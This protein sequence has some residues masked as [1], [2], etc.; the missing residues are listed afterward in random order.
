MAGIELTIAS[1]EVILS[2]SYGEVYNEELFNAKDN[3]PMING[4]FCPRIFGPIDSYE[5]LCET[6]I[7]NKASYCKICGVD[8]SIDKHNAR[9]R[10]GHIQLS[11][12]IVH[13]WLYKSNPNVLSILLNKPVKYIQ[14][15]V[16][17]ELHIIT[18]TLTNKFRIGQA[19]DTNAYNKI[20]NKGHMYKALSGGTAI[21]KLLSEVQPKQIR[22]LILAKYK[23]L[24]SEK[25]LNE[26]ND[27]LNIINNFAND[28]NNNII[29]SKII[30]NFLPVLP[31]ILRPVMI[32]PDSTHT[33]SELNE[34]YKHIIAINNNIKL[35]LTLL[36]NG[37]TIDFHEYIN[38]FKTLQYAINTLIDSTSGADKPVSH[39]TIALS[40]LSSLLKGK[41]GRFRYN[42]LGKRVDYSGRSVIAPGPKLAF[43]ECAI[44]YIIALK[45]FKP[46][47]HA[48]L[49]LRF[50]I[51]DVKMIKSVIINNPGIKEN[52]LEEVVKYC[53][54]IL[55]RAPTL[56][57][58]SMR[59]FWVKLTN[60]KAIRLHP[61][62]CSGFNADFDGDQMAIHVPLSF[63]ARIETILLII[64]TWNV[65]HPAHGSPCVLPTQDMIIGLYYMSLVS[66]Q[67]EDICFTSYIDVITSLLFKKINLHAKV[68]F[69][70]LRNG[71]YIVITSTP[72]RLLIMEAVPL[73]C[74]FIYKWTDPTFTKDHI[75]NIIA[76]VH[77]ICGDSKMIRFCETLMKLGF[78]YA[79]KSGLSVS[80]LDLNIPKLKQTLLNNARMS[81]IKPFQS[82]IKDIQFWKRW[83]DISFEI[84]NSIDLEAPDYNINQ[85]SI[86]IMF[87][88]GARGTLAQI[89]QLIGAKGDIIKFNGQLCKIPILRS[90][91]EGLNLIQFFYSTYSSRK[92]LIDTVLK[93]SDSGYLTRKLVEASREWI[94]S[95]FDC[96][97]KASLRIKPILNNSFIKNRLIG[98]VLLKPIIHYGKIIIHANDLIT[99]NNIN[100][101]LKYYNKYIYIRS[102][103]TCQSGN[104]VCK[105]CY[106]IDLNTN[107]LARLGSSVGVLAAQSIGEPGTQLTLR[108]FHKLDNI[109]D[110]TKYSQG[111]GKCLV[112][113]FSGIV[114]I[115]NLACVKSAL[116]G[117]MITNTK[118]ILSICQEDSITWTY[119]LFRGIHL[120]IANG[121]Y[122]NAGKIIGLNIFTSNNLLSLT[123][124]EIYIK[125]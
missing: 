109:E 46:F 71:N 54:V 111:I 79:N 100:T 9:S 53:P 57:K 103:L 110:K 18:K 12:P 30:I 24:S 36:R 47:I 56:H 99:K 95:E 49:M 94:I 120:L 125:T 92:S 28:N 59:A 98:R 7:L 69:S 44:P 25:D 108:T 48:K 118:C 16:D 62:T 21:L 101:V 40:S 3:K 2:W 20:W 61:L 77:D 4:L 124:G 10:F 11:V 60:E 78:K 66:S 89:R 68:K 104:G 81:A 58:L 115:S 75:S 27:K 63:K 70:L 45:L 38:S 117:I 50:E 105:L 6:P 42:I 33:S 76:L 80:I 14:D 26:L 51:K 55:N 85:T 15:L 102:P 19:I 13:I 107:R 23:G 91:R 43:N 5:C 8:L 72:G 41:K 1:S 74:G 67:Q 37:K 83:S 119:A 82:S 116:D 84:N 96:Y 90:Y 87:N 122:I 17:C 114:K 123:N 113:P 88:S 64:S 31:A 32:L 121:S 52:M 97:T 73:E 93:T 34:L 106:G 35:K 22:K 65:F 86:Q 39:N 112:A 29:S